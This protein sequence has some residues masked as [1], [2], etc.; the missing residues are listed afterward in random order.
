MPR[1]VSA[2]L[3]F[4]PIDD[5]ALLLQACLG[6]PDLTLSAWEAWRARV[7]LD[8]LD[9]ASRRLLPL[10][11]HALRKAGAPASALAPYA[12]AQR[13]AWMAQ[14]ATSRK[15]ARV[16]DAL[17]VAGTPTL[18]MKGAALAAAQY[19]EPALRPMGDVDMMVRQ[20]DALRAFRVLG[21]AG[22]HACGAEPAPT[23]PGMLAVRHAAALDNGEPGGPIDLH[24]RAHGAY[25]DSAAA[26]W[27]WIRATPLRTGGASTLAPDSADL[28][29]GVCLHGA[30]WSRPP[31]IRW[32]AD[33]LVLLRGARLDWAYLLTQTGRLRA[34]L[35]MATTL[36][37]LK[38]AFDAPVPVD[39]IAAL[40]AAKPRAAERRLFLADQRPPG[41]LD[42]PTA[43]RLHL[44]LAA[45]TSRGAADWARYAVA[46]KRRRSVG[47][48]T[49]WLHRKLVGRT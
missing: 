35:P 32:V 11:A 19:D 10:L 4:L 26:E 44:R 5:Q 31:A 28:L 42:L 1:P 25:V 13:R 41:T 22:F 23:S 24:W 17:A 3:P 16:I 15:A 6:P 46:L 2:A 48:V 39:V 34:S 29:I 45:L 12:E 20:S 38:A 40:T 43:M 8:Q 47:E 33:S 14:Q 21:E 18:L 36:G 37:Y 27:L 30:R 7:D 49:G 9:V